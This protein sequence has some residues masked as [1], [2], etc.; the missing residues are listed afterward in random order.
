MPLSL[1]FRFY[2][3]VHIMH[4]KDRMVAGEEVLL[5]LFGAQPQLVNSKSPAP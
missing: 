4:C 3:N 2:G 1:K 5:Q